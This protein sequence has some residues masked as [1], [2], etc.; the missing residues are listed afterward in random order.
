LGGSCANALG[1]PGGS[2]G[3]LVVDT[4]EAARTIKSKNVI[5]FTTYPPLGQ[6]GFS[7]GRMVTQ[8]GSIMKES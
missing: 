4:I 7:M 3:S 6:S 2:D 8:S 5:D 1:A